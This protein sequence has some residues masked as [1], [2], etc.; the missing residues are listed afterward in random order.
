MKELILESSSFF[1]AA[2]VEL[3]LIVNTCLRKIFI[4]W[5][6]MYVSRHKCSLAP[7]RRAT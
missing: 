5:H 2:T 4:Y 1:Y 3:P 6:R 7:G